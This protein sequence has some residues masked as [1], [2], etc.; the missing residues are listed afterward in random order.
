MGHCGRG[1]G[2]RGASK[3]DDDNRGKA[4]GAVVYGELF[5]RSV[6]VAFVDFFLCSEKNL[7]RA[8]STEWES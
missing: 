6:L 3:N 5:F 4:G 7:C 1:R 2:T 8:A